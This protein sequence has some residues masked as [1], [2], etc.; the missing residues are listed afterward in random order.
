MDRVKGKACIVTG[1]SLG[2]GQAC[3]R[4]LADEGARIAVFDVLD[5]QGEALT[6]QLR[7]RGV[8]ARYWHVDVADEKSVAT[9]VGAVEAHFGALDVLVN[10]AGIA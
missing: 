5:A 9:A 1:G 7:T 4:R 6:A 10:N 3:C 2:I 8:E